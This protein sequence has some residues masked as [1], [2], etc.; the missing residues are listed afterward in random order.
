L[1][2]TPLFTVVRAPAAAP[3]LRR[4]RRRSPATTRPILLHQS[5][6]GEPNFTSLSLVCL[7]VPHLAAGE[8]AAA[9]GSKGGTKG[10][11]AK[12][13]K[14]LGSY[15]QKDSFPFAMCWLKLFKSI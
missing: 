1:S 5:I 9:V 15:T 2:I 7:P 13:L 12:D 14:L 6:A 3:S 11:I 8:H 10:L 4:R